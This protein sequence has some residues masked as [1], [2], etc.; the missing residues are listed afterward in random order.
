MD[1]LQRPKH[2]PEPIL[3]YTLKELTIVWHLYGGHDFSPPLTSPAASPSLP[4]QNTNSSTHHSSFSSG[5]THSATQS[6]CP[7]PGS[8]HQVGHVSG[9][10]GKK[11][12]MGGGGRG[13]WSMTGGRGRD[14]TIRMEIEVD[15]VHIY[16][17][18]YI[19]IL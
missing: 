1:Q 2:F 13:G 12:S 3:Q 8:K 9:G 16:V 10:R 11:V 7:H 5:P 4:H 19:H 18:T 6:A 15:K 14:N 17:C